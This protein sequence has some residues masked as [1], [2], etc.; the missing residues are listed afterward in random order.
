MLG[1]VMMVIF[2]AMAQL[3]PVVVEVGHFS[4]DMYYVIFPALL[5]GTLLMVVGFWWMPVVLPYGGLLV[6]VSMVT[7]LA[8]TMLTLKKAERVTLTVKSVLASNIFLSLS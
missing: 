8:E 5:I 3:V 6:L 2:G 1:F 7:F 4:V